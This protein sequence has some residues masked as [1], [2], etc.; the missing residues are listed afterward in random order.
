M[1]IDL[2]IKML[3]S[4]T[5]GLLVHNPFTCVCLLTHNE[6]STPVYTRSLPC[7]IVVVIV[8]VMSV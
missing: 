4:F 1:I 3:Y 5:R 8:V 7:Y 2:L 6:L